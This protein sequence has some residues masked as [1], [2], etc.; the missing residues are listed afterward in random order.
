M[1]NVGNTTWRKRTSEGLERDADVSPVSPFLQISLDLCL[2]WFCGRCFVV[3][4]FLLAFAFGEICFLSS[5]IPVVDRQCLAL[6]RQ[7]RE[8][9]KKGRGNIRRRPGR[10][11]RQDRQNQK[12]G[13]RTGEGAGRVRIM[14]FSFFP[15]F[16]FPFTPM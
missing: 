8:K 10:T 4:L 7:C 5:L 1:D 16:L 2:V 12:E 11:R 3:C 6:V 14:F 13:A 9:K 15:S